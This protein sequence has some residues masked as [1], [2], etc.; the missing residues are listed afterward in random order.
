[1]EQNFHDI[2]QTFVLYRVNLIQD[3]L[4]E[5]SSV[6]SPKHKLKCSEL[7]IYK[8]HKAESGEI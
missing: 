8:G 1:M 6:G 4:Q 5:K 7:N 3:V 2:T